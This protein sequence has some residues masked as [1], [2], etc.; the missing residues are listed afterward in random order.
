MD[1]TDP[2]RQWISKETGMSW[3]S[4]ING[5]VLP[6]GTHTIHV[7]KSKIL[8]QILMFYLSVL[9]RNLPRHF[10]FNHVYSNF[11]FSTPLKE[12]GK[13]MKWLT[14]AGLAAEKPRLRRIHTLENVASFENVFK[15]G[16]GYETVY[17]DQL[18]ILTNKYGWVTFAWA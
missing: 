14:E 15:D 4:G 6:R 13:Y 1:I 17:K 10:P 3:G 5:A 11:L 7:L 18:E 9:Q 2:L 8:K 12:S 16:E